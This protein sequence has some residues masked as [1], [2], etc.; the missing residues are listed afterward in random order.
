MTKLA[1]IGATGHAGGLMLD[2][3]VERGLDVTA[4]VRDA[5]KLKQDVPALEKDVFKLTASDLTA[6]DAVIVAYRAAE[7]DEESYH[8]LFAHLKEILTGSNVRLLIMG[9]PA[10][11]ILTRATA[12]ST[13][14]PWTKMPL[15]LPHLVSLPRPAKSSSSPSSTGPTFHQ[16]TC[17]ILTEKR[18]AM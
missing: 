3:A 2:K 10:R 17:S 7:G 16:P 4:I 15:G 8:K 1:V 6:F 18:R 9:G 5:K 11:F 12:R 14:R 13:G